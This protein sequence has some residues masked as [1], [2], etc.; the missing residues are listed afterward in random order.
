MTIVTDLER[1]AAHFARLEHTF[2]E[3]IE[4]SLEQA[5]KL[6]QHD[7]QQRIGHYQQEV[8]PFPAWAELAPETQVERARLGFTPNDPL[9][10]TG[11][12]YRSIE[13]DIGYREATIGSRE[14]VAA[15]M[16]FGTSRV[17]PRPFLGPAWFSNIDRIRAIVGHF[18][19]R[20]LEGKPTV[21]YSFSGAPALRE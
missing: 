13:Y 19:V 1:L 18:T 14:K 17:P 12:L 3:T 15:W 16:E 2:A 11:S 21:G 8:G 6:I 4:H 9:Y 10:R 7:A 20:A 5:A